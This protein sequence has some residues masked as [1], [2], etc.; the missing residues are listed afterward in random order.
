MKKATRFA[1]IY[2]NF[3]ATYN[4]DDYHYVTTSDY[5]SFMEYLNEIG[6]KYNEFF[7]KS[8]LYTAQQ[9]TMQ[10]RNNLPGSKIKRLCSE[11]YESLTKD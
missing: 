11:I 6:F 2:K 9:A 5:I 8:W 3:L 4:L 10:V 7:Y 1:T